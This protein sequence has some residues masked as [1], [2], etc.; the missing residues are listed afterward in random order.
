MSISVYFYTQLVEPQ[1]HL[2]DMYIVALE[3]FRQLPQSDFRVTRH[4]HLPP[5]P[6]IFFAAPARSER[7]FRVVELPKLSGRGAIV[8]QSDKS[9]CIIMMTPAS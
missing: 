3:N 7:C 9:S 5:F 8:L 6:F 4:S 1:T 2:L